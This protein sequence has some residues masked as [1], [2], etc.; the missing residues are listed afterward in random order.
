MTEPKLLYLKPPTH[1]P[2]LLRAPFPALQNHR[3][4]PMT[5]AKA[6]YALNNKA[7][8]KVPHDELGDTLHLY[9][10]GQTARNITKGLSS[11]PSSYLQQAGAMGPSEF[12]PQVLSLS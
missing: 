9:S 12:Q 8:Q 11:K 4:S 6:P 7:I 1:S 10:W 2:L 5:G 3:L